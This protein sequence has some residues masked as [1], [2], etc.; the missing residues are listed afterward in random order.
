V[1]SCCYSWFSGCSLSSS[2]CCCDG[3]PVATAAGS[4]PVVIVLVLLMSVSCCPPKLG[5][6]LL[7]CYPIVAVVVVCV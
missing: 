5:S 3:I 1:S 2:R 6:G 4:A 7:F